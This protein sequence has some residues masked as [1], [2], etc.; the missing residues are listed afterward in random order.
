MIKEGEAPVVLFGADRVVRV[1]VTLHAAHLYAHESSPSCIHAIDDRVDTVLFING[2]PFVVIFCQTVEACRDE[3][4][5]AF[6]EHVSGHLT[7]NKV[8]PAH[9]TIEGGD[10]PIAVRPDIT[11]S[12]VSE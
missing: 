4:L 6:R 8:V 9:I 3:V 10:N 7:D 2:S 1:P 12:V 5:L 11:R